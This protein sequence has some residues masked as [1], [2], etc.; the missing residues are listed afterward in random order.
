[1]ATEEMV[2][3]GGTLNL[4]LLGGSATDLGAAMGAR[5]D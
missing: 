3:V 1:L 4:K 2:F 5:R